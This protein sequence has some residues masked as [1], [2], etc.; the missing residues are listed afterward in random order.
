MLPI[1]M[2]TLMIEPRNAVQMSE[3]DTRTGDAAF[4]TRQNFPTQ[5][6]SFIEPIQL[7][8]YVTE[9]ISQ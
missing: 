3:Y 6:T 8:Y 1:D 2:A 5:T 7:M 9:L 4:V